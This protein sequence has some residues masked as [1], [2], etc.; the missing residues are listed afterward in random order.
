MADSYSSDSPVTKHKEDKFNRWLFSKRI[1]DVIANRIDS[2]S[3]VIGLYGAWGNGKTSVLNFIEESLNDDPDV[4]CIKFNP[5]RFGAEEEL[6]KAFFQ[7]IAHAI[8]AKLITKTDK[9]KD[10]V[11]SFAPAIT[12]IF[13]AA[14]VGQAISSFIPSIELQKLKERIEGELEKAQKRVLILIDDVDR[15]EKTEIHALFRLV[16][17]TADFKY[18]AYILAFDKDI[19]AASL[20]DRYAN[21][22]NNAGEDFLEKII[23]VPLH[24]PLIDQSVLIKFCFQGIDEALTVAG[25]EL[26]QDQASNYASKFTRYFS[27]VVTTPRKAKLYGNI[28]LFSLPILKG[29]VDT[30]ELMLVEAIR[31]FYQPIYDMLRINKELFSGTFRESG[32]TDYNS[33]KVKIKQLVDQAIGLCKHADKEKII[34]LLKDL[35][36]KINSSYHN[37]FYGSEWYEV[38]DE[39]QRVCAPNYYSRYF[40][41]SILEEDISDVTIKEILQQCE[42]WQDHSE[43]DKNPLNEFLT[44]EN[45]EKVISKLRVRANNL[46]EKISFSLSIA[47]AQKSDQL[48]YTLKLFDWFTPVIQGAMLIS[49]LI[50]NV[51]KNNRLEYIKVIMDHAP[52]LDFIFDLLEWVKKYDEQRPEKTDVL[53]SADMDELIKYLICRIESELSHNINIVEAVP[54]NLPTLFRVV[55]EYIQPNFVNELLNKLLPNEPWL[56]IHIITAYLGIAEGGNRSSPHRSD[57]KFEQYK[58]IIK[59]INVEILIGGIEQSFKQHVLFSKDFPEQDDHLEE[60]E[61]IF[62]KQFYWLYKNQ[63]DEKYLSENSE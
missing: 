7:D 50:Q 40:T 4:L 20:Q 57:L 16:K 48:P 35:F 33:E 8:E 13:G 11:K 18:T 14:E 26:T 5:W 55:N 21:S 42:F 22:S 29:E 46:S 37:T 56:I 63:K 24:L 53:S 9:A 61:F 38:W 30:V 43:F 58:Q 27:S 51:D 60:G 49:D 25:I 1:A 15:L 23:Q 32:Y 2:S 28:L 41:Y 34:E 45:A 36:P 3:I 6:L 17:L 44:N 39:K 19:V 47:I 54:R 59:Q 52:N 10:A 62:I 12:S 31:V